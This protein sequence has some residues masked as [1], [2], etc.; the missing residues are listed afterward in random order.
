MSAVRSTV[1]KAPRLHWHLQGLLWPSEAKAAQ[2]LGGAGRPRRSVFALP[3]AGMV[4]PDFLLLSCGLAAQL[5]QSQGEMNPKPV[6]LQS[7]KA[8]EAGC[9]PLSPFPGEGNSL[10]SRS[11][12]FAGPGLGD[13]MMQ[14]NWNCSSC[15]SCEVIIELFAPLYCWSFLNG[16]LS[17]PRTV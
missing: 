1:R 15:P 9:S 7:L 13:G 6:L 12:L 2:V 16:L 3:I 14:V 17:S 10:G 11:S 4:A 5:C 8:W